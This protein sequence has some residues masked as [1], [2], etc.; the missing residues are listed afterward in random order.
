[1][2]VRPRL[3][4]KTALTRSLFK[5][6]PGTEQQAGGCEFSGTGTVCLR[7]ATQFNRRS[8]LWLNSKTTSS[9]TST[10]PTG[11]ARKSASPKPKCRAWWPFA[12]NSRKPSRSRARA[13]PVRCTWRSR[14]PCW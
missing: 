7:P 6:V 11:V 10:L 12:K 3:G 13:S 4:A 5:S 14:P 1:M 2:I 9:P 8:S